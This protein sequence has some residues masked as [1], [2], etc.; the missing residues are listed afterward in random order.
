[1]NKLLL[2]LLLFSN[3]LCFSQPGFNFNHE[4]KSKNLV[5]VY[6]KNDTLS[7]IMMY[8][9]EGEFF[10]ANGITSDTTFL[11]IEYLKTR[12][13]A[14]IED[15]DISSLGKKI[16]LDRFV[17][18][19]ELVDNWSK[20]TEPTIKSEINY[21]EEIT[22]EK[23]K[24]TGEITYRTPHGN[25]GLY[26]VKYVKSGVVDYYLSVYVGGSTL[27][28]NEKG[29]YILFDNGKKIIRNNEHIDVS[30]GDEGWMYNGF[31]KLTKEN[32]TLLKNNLITDVK[33]FIYD[34]EIDN[35]SAN[36]IRQYM[37]CLSK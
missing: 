7:D 16:L 8:I 17:V 34:K 36:N 31:I 26:I 11:Y 20:K 15:I 14:N 24:F 32:I 22:N 37:K 30:Y 35:K 29:V 3:I 5:K 1:M 23:D 4:V 33:L 21:C 18:K 10:G 2:I 13:F 9:P 12:G 25:L 27:N 28:T 19:Q 6:K